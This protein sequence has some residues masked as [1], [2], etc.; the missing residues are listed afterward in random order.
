MRPVVL[1]ASSLLACGTATSS[2]P[3][4]DRAAEEE[5]ILTQVFRY[6]LRQFV[7]APDHAV[8]NPVCVAIISQGQLIDPAETLLRRVNAGVVKN[9]ACPP[10]TPVRLVAGPVEWIKTDDVRVKGSYQDRTTS[11]ALEYRVAWES[12]AWAC[13]GP[14][15]GYDPL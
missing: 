8:I 15:I 11:T 1:L 12:G 2:G 6:E 14:I 3:S 4:A 7:E 10:A 9:S 13:L 5:P